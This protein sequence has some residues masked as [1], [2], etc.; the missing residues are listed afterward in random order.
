M[1]RRRRHG[2]RDR[3]DV[4]WGEEALLALEVI[5]EAGLTAVVTLAVHREGEVREGW[6]R[7]HLRPTEQAGADVVGLNCIRGPPTMLPLIAR[8]RDAVDCHVAA[9]PVPYRTTDAEPTF[10][11]LSDPGRGGA[12]AF[13]TALDPLFTCTRHELTD[14]TMAALDLGVSYLGICCGA[15]P[16]HVRA[17]AEAAGK[18]PEASRYAPDMSKHSFLGTAGGSRR[19]TAN[20]PPTCRRTGR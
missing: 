10:Q 6:T 19:A 4:P 1:D 3:R 14:F 9:L 18:A 11:S 2:L 5:K 15:G 13:P 17:M 8:I 12:Q 7:G 16:Q 20:T